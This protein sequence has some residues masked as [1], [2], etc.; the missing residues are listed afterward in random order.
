MAKSKEE[1]QRGELQLVSLA[2]DGA[3]G[4]LPG[5]VADLER[6]IA[7]YNNMLSI[8]QRLVSLRELILQDELKK[9]GLAVCTRH[10]PSDISYLSYERS[11]GIYPEAEMTLYY[12]LHQEQ[13][14]RY[15]VT[16]L[17]CPDHISYCQTDRFVPVSD[18]N[19]TKSAIRKIDREEVYAYFGLPC[20]IPDYRQDPSFRVF[21]DSLRQL[22]TA[23]ELNRRV[24]TAQDIVQRVLD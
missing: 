18:K 24:A 12:L 16:D 21:K 2:Y 5:S 17:V 1:L 13:P 6:I 8:H 10:Y 20:N 23:V 15:H 4:S 3:V 22:S 11:I 9:Q 19:A 7:D 14:L